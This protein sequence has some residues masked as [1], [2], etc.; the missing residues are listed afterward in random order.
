[1]LVETLLR[2]RMPALSNLA[3]RTQKRNPRPFAAFSLHTDTDKKPEE[4]TYGTRA[5][6]LANRHSLADHSDR[7]AAGR[8]E[9]IS[10][11]R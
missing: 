8:A 6:A 3:A 10:R 11:S 2:R 4:A 7:L 1:V 5:I 9:L